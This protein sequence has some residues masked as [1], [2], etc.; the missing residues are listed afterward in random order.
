M[1][2]DLTTPEGRQAANEAAAKLC[3]LYIANPEGWKSPLWG[4][5]G[6]DICTVAAPDFLAGLRPDG[7]CDES[8]VDWK[9]W[10][11]VATAIRRGGFSL[12]VGMPP[13]PT[14]E[15]GYGVRCG[16]TRIHHADPVAALLLAA[17]HAGLL[18]IARAE[19]K[20]EK[21]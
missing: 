13:I 5:P 15:G 17:G 10:G 14:Q 18:D 2:I 1:R 12:H 6:R 8:K 20:G 19:G 11:R 7:T 16:G 4:Y 3:G 21:K 9:L